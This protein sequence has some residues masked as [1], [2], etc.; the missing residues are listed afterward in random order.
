MKLLIN[1]PA[2][3][4]STKDTDFRDHE[5]AAK[6]RSFATARAL[7]ATFVQRFIKIVERLRGGA[8]RRSDR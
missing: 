4:S 7:T 3:I 8:I 1:S 6:P 5:Q 2:P